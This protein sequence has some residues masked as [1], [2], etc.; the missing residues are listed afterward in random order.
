ME[1]V[2]EHPPD[3]LPFN[4][5]MPRE[6]TAVSIDA[7]QKQVSSVTIGSCNVLRAQALPVA[8]RGRHFKA[9]GSPNFPVE[10]GIGLL[11]PARTNP[12]HICA[13]STIEPK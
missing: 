13:Y 3:E 8:L 12:G 6:T 11:E 1:H 5:C 2:G 9:P 4:S 7:C 10:N